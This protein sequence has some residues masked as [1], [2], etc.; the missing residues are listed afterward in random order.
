[1]RGSCMAAKYGQKSDC[2]SSVLMSCA[3][4]VN[5]E[6]VGRYT[7]TGKHKLTS[8]LFVYVAVRCMG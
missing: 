4:K 3:Q 6:V 8:R 7:Q 5:K 2:A 1:M